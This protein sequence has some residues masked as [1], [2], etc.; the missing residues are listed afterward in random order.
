MRLAVIE[1][2]N[3][4]RIGGVDPAA[5]VAEQLVR[6][7]GPRSTSHLACVRALR[8]LFCT[9][10]TMRRGRF[11]PVDVAMTEARRVI[12]LE[13]TGASW[14]LPHLVSRIPDGQLF[15]HYTPPPPAPKLLG[16]RSVFTKK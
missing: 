8:W 15:E 5:D 14:G 12:Q 2:R 9:R 10:F 4:A 6:R 11:R 7:G 16:L 1:V 13:E 3:A